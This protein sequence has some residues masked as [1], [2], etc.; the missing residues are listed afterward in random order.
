[1]LIFTKE[2]ILFNELNHF[3]SDNSLINFYYVRRQS[4]RP[5]VY[6]LCAISFLVQWR[7]MCLFVVIVNSPQ[8]KRFTPKKPNWF[9]KL[10]GTILQKITGIA[11]C[12]LAKSEEIF[13]IASIIDSLLIEEFFLELRYQEQGNQVILY[14]TMLDH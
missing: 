11:S 14:S 13:E 1:M 5:V 9:T 6:S 2:R 8:L 12:P 10:G 3:F 7:D 4:N